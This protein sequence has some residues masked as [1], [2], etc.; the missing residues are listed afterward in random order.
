MFTYGNYVKSII[1]LS[2]SKYCQMFIS[3]TARTDWLNDR[4]TDCLIGWTNKRT[5]DRPTNLVFPERWCVWFYLRQIIESEVLEVLMVFSKDTDPEMSAVRACAE[6]AL[7]TAVELN[8][9]KQNEAKDWRWYHHKLQS[10]ENANLFPTASFL[11]APSHAFL[12]GKNLK[13]SENEVAFCQS[14][15][16]TAEKAMPSSLPE[17]QLYFAA[18]G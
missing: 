1:R 16:E 11:P 12:D 10:L 17:H 13:G 3:P 18:S 7:E 8:L 5:T 6:R 14:F 15:R 2:F 4:P 9:I